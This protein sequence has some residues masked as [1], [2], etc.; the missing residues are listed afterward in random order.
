MWE[1]VAKTEH[2][3]N[4]NGRRVLLGSTSGDCVSRKHTENAMSPTTCRAG[5]HGKAREQ[6]TAQR[7]TAKR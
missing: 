1:A 4:V 7:E 3:D 5:E 6:S 2:C